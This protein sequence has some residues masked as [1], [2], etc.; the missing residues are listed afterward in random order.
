MKPTVHRSQII[1]QKEK[2]TLLASL[3]LGALFLATLGRASA[4]ANWTLQSWDVIVVGAGTAGIIVADRL[5][6]AGYKTLLLQQGGQSYGI[7]GGRERP[8]WL[9]NTTLSRVDVPGL[10]K[11]K[12]WD[13]RAARVFFCPNM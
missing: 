13:K 11:C 8:G 9:D 6:E 7:T 3:W 4:V 5:S 2:M 1:L 10:C 12:P